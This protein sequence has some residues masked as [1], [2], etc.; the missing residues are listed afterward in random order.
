MMNTNNTN[1]I[2]Q[3]PAI[4]SS[5]SLSGVRRSRDTDASSSNSS[6]R[7][8]FDSLVVIQLENDSEDNVISSAESGDHIITS[9]CLQHDLS[10]DLKS[11]VTE[12]TSMSSNDG[13]RETSS[14]SEICLN[15]DE[16]ESS[17]MLKPNPPSHDKQL[18]NPT[19]EEIEAFFAVM[20]SKEH[21]RFADKYNY[22]IVNDVPMDG[23]Y[24]WVLL[25][26]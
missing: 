15:S 25:K 21:K 12:T 8:K 19:A 18:N 9:S 23:R 16:M 5:N 26:P 1:T 10:L 7:I 17:S 11:F 13:F 6:K 3:I 20:E 24:Q 22:D 4:N 14:S 2:D